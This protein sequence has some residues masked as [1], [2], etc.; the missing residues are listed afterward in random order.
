[1]I[2]AHPAAGHLPIGFGY[3]FRCS[4][5]YWL[6]AELAD[7]KGPVAAAKQLAGLCELAVLPAHQGHGVG[8]ALHR[9]LLD[10]LGTEWASLLAMPGDDRPEQRLYRTLGYRYAGPYRSGPD[11][12]VLDLL[13]LHADATGGHQAGARQ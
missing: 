12:P 4:P 6:G 1:M 10:T 7:I 5:A 3:G 8:T 13:L 11:G 9:A 2:T